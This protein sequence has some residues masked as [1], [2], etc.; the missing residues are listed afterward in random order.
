MALEC[1][2]DALS[3]IDASDPE[4]LQAL[5]QTCNNALLDPMLWVWAIGLTV[6]CAV[7][8]AF[9]G[10]AKGRWVSGMIWGLALGPI[11]WVVVALSRA[12]PPKCPACG[13]TNAANAK[14]CGHCGINL[15][16]AALN[17]DR[18]SLNR[19][20]GPRGE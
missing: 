6:V 18:A 19:N 12:S 4:A 8:G 15:K 1:S 16:V 14:F 2:L 3:T 11:G 7:V 17:A 9:I 10:H 20:S 13:L 5:L